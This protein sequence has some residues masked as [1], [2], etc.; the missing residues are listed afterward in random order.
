MMIGQL[1]QGTVALTPDDGKQ[2][3]HLILREEGDLGQWRGVFPW[4]HGDFC[5]IPRTGALGVFGEVQ[6]DRNLV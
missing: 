4:L 1:K 3:T 6:R 2:A 5:T